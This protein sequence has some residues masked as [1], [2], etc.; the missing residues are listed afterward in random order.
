M[1]LSTAQKRALSLLPKISGSLS[2]VCSGLIVW[3][4]M[5]DRRKRSKTYHR[6][7]A[8]VSCVDISTSFWLALSAWPI[9]GDDGTVEWAAGTKISCRVQGFFTQFGIA[10]SIYNATLSVFYV[11]VIKYG[12]KTVRLRKYEV[13]LH[14][15]PL[16]WGFGTALTGLLLD[17]YHNANLWCF[18]APDPN[19]GFSEDKA[20][21]LRWVMFYV[22]LWTMI[23]IVTVNIIV[24]YRHV[25]SLELPSQQFG[26]S[27]QYSPTEPTHGETGGELD[28]TTQL[29]SINASSIPPAVFSSWFGG[30]RQRIQ[31]QTIARRVSNERS[32][33]VARQCFGYAIAFYI[34]WISM[35]VSQSCTREDGGFFWVSQVI[36]KI[37]RIIQAAGAEVPYA[38]LVISAITVPLQGLPNLIVYLGPRIRRIRKQES[39]MSWIRAA[40]VSVR[41][42]GTSIAGATSEFD[43]SD[44][45]REDQS[46][47]T[48]GED[49]KTGSQ[50]DNKVVV[51]TKASS[52]EVGQQT[53]K[54]NE[55]NSEPTKDETKMSGIN[56]ASATPQAVS[57]PQKVTFEDIEARDLPPSMPRRRPQM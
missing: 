34:N 51:D 41:S 2:I 4:T 3:M 22:P 5:K 42:R 9:P 57:I 19:G 30:G 13:L 23:L 32:K 31:T 15:I 55:S 54:I 25:Q 40:A 50:S 26:V 45:F 6:L 37:V 53:I 1:S 46:H 49:P 11:L 18:I 52:G 48:R 47:Q 33:E 38:L 36:F 7:L 17:A 28:S 27:R 35:S 24:V 43:R 16:L 14:G 20:N 39:N 56:T 29:D 10:S 8:G 21:L 44:L 12:W